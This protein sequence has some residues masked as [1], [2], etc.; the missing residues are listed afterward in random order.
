MPSSSYRVSRDRVLSYALGAT[1]FLYLLQCLSPL[2]FGG[3]SVRYLSYAVSIA[4]GTAPDAAGYPPGYPAFIALLDRLHIASGF[5]FNLANC[6]FFAIGLIS[7]RRIFNARREG[8]GNLVALITLMSWLFIRVIAMPIPEPMFFGSSLVAVA[9]MDE[10]ARTTRGSRRAV[11]LLAAAVL[12]AIAMTTR[13]VG[14]CLVVPLVWIV[15][16]DPSA[17]RP[18]KRSKLSR[19]LLA[20]VT[21]IA[22]AAVSILVTHNSFR[23]YAA[24]S[25]AQYLHHDFFHFAVQHMIGI[26]WTLG[27]VTLNFPGTRF[28][29][30]GITLAVAG[31][32]LSTVAV[33]IIRPHMPTSPV[34]VYVV[35][36]L[37]VLVAWSQFAD[38]L[39]IP[40]F[41]LIVGY[42]LVSPRAYSSRL[43]RNAGKVYLALFMIAGLAALAYSTRITFAGDNFTKEYGKAGGMSFGSSKNAEWGKWHDK[44]VMILRARYEHGI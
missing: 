5:T 31:M 3:D 43:V 27:S 18:Q 26:F 11:M 23:K 9:L 14:V 15:L 39:W 8:T 22:L 6:A 16:R 21:L 12:S 37:A 33:W 44:W 42:V 13:V 7:V 40:V 32:V 20:L 10:S 34:G 30:L 25:A 1:S 4:D 2:R 36:F 41:P 35:T 19:W 38:R 28:H 17:A 29:S 24:D